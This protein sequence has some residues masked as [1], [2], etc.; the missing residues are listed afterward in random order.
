MS[1]YFDVIT[2]RVETVKFSVKADKPSE[3]IKKYEEGD[4]IDGHHE[5]D[6]VYT[7]LDVEEQ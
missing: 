4:Y 5:E 3:A 2:K 1:K 6:Y 7:V